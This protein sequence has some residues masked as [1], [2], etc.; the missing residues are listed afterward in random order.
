MVHLLVFFYFFF[1]FR[2]LI[3]RRKTAKTGFVLREFEKLVEGTTS[4]TLI[5]SI[6]ISGRK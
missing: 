1:Y 5:N 4:G 6:P 3:F 2:L